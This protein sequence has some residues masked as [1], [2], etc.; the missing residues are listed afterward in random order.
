MLDFNSQAYLTLC[1]LYSN[2]SNSAVK[3]I[4]NCGELENILG[5]SVLKLEKNDCT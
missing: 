4:S 5:S 3:L 1:R 2:Q